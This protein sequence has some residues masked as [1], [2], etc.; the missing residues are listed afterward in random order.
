MLPEASITNS[1]SISALEQIS[2]YGS[3]FSVLYKVFTRGLAH[4][5][6]FFTLLVFIDRSASKSPML[7]ITVKD[8]LLEYLLIPYP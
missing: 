2:L 6:V 7:E 4:R 8:P 1:K 5:T 3:N